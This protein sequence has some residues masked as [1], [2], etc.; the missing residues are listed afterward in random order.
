MTPFRIIQIAAVIGVTNSVFF[1]FPMRVHAED[2]DLGSTREQWRQ[3]V[4][5]VK[6]RVQEEAAQRRLEQ[7]RAGAQPS[8]E[9]EARRLSEIVRS[10]DSL[11]PG[12]VVMTDRGMFVFK[13][14]SNEAISARDFEPVEGPGL[15][16]QG[17]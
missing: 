14:R 4:R 7:P 11:V 17:K 8:R 1:M 6:R 2:A 10:D 15:K 16:A 9:D 3:H 12:D 5:D 13:G